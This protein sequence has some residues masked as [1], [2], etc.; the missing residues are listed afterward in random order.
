MPVNE[1]GRNGGCIDNASA[2]H[3]LLLF[4]PLKILF[5][6]WISV[7]HSE[8]VRKET[9]RKNAMWCILVYSTRVT[10]CTFSIIL[11]SITTSISYSPLAVS[12]HSTPSERTQRASIFVS[13]HLKNC[14][15]QDSKSQKL[16]KGRLC[17]EKQKVHNFF[18]V[19][20]NKST[21][22]SG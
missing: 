14:R 9:Y 6:F 8:Y 12:E 16:Q 17:N 21:D 18:H 7:I 15:D 2:S 4:S 10:Y 3:L 19:V 20:K 13:F 11:H 5:F 22:C 1:G